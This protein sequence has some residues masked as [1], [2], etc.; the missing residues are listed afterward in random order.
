VPVIAD[1]RGATR[2]SASNNCAQDSSQALYAT[3]RQID[4]ALNVRADVQAWKQENPKEAERMK[5]LLELGEK[6]KRTILPFGSARADWEW[7]M[8]TIGS[9]L[10]SNPIEN[11]EMAL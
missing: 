4:R 6:L 11:L 10:A 2:V 5:R 3:F 9:S 1:G 7:G 8:A